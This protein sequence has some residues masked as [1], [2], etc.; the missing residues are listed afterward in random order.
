MIKKRELT[1]RENKGMKILKKESRNNVL[2]HKKSIKQAV[3]A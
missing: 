1:I 2:L 3:S